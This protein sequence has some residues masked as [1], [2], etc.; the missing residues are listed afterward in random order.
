MN[1][2]FIASLTK[3]HASALGSLNVSEHYAKKL[4]NIYL[5]RFIFYLAQADNNECLDGSNN[6]HANADCENI[7]GSF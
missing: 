5:L 1:K 6:C 7:P 2:S 3:L 4:L